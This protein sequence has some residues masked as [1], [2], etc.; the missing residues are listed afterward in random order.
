MTGD[1]DY[2][3]ALD[4]LIDGG[5]AHPS[6]G[7]PPRRPVPPRALPRHLAGPVRRLPRPANDRVALTRRRR[8][9]A[10]LTRITRRTR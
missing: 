9:L 8:T 7:G 5:P 3:P 6:W 10:A 2:G 1:H 4:R